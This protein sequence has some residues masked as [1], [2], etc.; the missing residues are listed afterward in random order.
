MA[1]VFKFDEEQLR[2]WQEW[3]AERPQVIKDMAASHPPNRLYRMTSTGQRVTLMSYGEDRTCRV[4]VT[5][6]YNFVS[7]ERQVFGVAIDDLVEC[8]LPASGE[9]L[10]C[11]LDGGEADVAIA[12]GSSKEERIA[13]IGRAARKKLGEGGV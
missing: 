3:L 4:A 7:H 6:K 10:G 9:L 11:V 1:E 5:G 13:A 2:D 8:D 12:E